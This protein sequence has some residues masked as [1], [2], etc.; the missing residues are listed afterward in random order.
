MQALPT[1][2]LLAGGWL[3]AAGPQEPA[4]EPD[5]PL[6][7]IWKGD[8]VCATE[9]PSCETERIVLSITDI[10]DKPGYVLIR[11]ERIAD[12]KTISLGAGESQYN[13]AQH[14]LVMQA[15]QR[16]WT[17]TVTGEHIEGTLA[18]PDNTVLRRLALRKEV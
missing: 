9:T 6:A 2:L 11:A 5:P 18:L 4:P 10:T 16:V 1:F 7:G 3:C 8:A 12:G 13:R 14:T 17:L 15:E